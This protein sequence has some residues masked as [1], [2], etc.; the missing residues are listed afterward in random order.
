MGATELPGGGLVWESAGR[1]VEVLPSAQPGA[2]ELRIPLLAEGD[3]M[4]S[5][6]RTLVTA[7]GAHGA[8]VYDPQLGRSAKSSDPEV[9][10]QYRK[11]AAYAGAWMGEADALPSQGATTE[12]VSPT[13]KLILAVVIIVIAVV[14]LLDRLVLG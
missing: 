4:I 2:L 9:V 11:T 7:A 14:A 5:L 3:F 8:Q 1:L 10:E 13:T 6:L 12:L